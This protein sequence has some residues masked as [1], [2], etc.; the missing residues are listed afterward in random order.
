MDKVVIEPLQIEK[1]K[2]QKDGLQKKKRLIRW[3]NHVVA[4]ANSSSPEKSQTVMRQ[5]LLRDLSHLK[6]HR[7]LDQATLPRVAKPGNP[8]GNVPSNVRR[9]EARKG[10]RAAGKKATVRGAKAARISLGHTV[11]QP[12]KISSKRTTT[13]K[14]TSLKACRHQQVERCT[15]L[16]HWETQGPRISREQT[17]ESILPHKVCSPNENTRWVSTWSRNVARA[18]AEEGN[19]ARQNLCHYVSN[20][21]PTNEFEQLIA[22]ASGVLSGDRMARYR[23]WFY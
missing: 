17:P 18:L 7:T 6:T 4:T 23:L 12:S 22:F 19:C 20:H 9:S 2:E 8:T 1:I 21:I 10:K 16:L 15:Y 14:D 3:K 5:L 13:E 11:N